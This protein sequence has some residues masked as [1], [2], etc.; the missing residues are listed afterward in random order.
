VGGIV[1]VMVPIC[2]ENRLRFT[3]RLTEGI[4]EIE[5]ALG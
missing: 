3:A 2:T 1:S 5:L 4:P